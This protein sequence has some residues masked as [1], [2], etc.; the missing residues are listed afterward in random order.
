MSSQYVVDVSTGE[1]ST[2]DWTPPDIYVSTVTFPKTPATF[3]SAKLSISE[4]NVEGIGVDSAFAGVFQLDTGYFWVA[5][6]TA[7]EDTNYI[8]NA[9]DG[10]LFRC[11]VRPEDYQQDGFAI[12]TTD[13]SGVPADP[14]TISVIV[15]RAI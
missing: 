15:T 11:Y 3:A 4:G 1:S 2:E 13:L 6:M 7:Q 5:F 10:G 8:V 12:S 14:Q 9:F